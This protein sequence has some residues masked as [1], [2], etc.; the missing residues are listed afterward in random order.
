MSFSLVSSHTHLRMLY[1]AICA[2]QTS[3]VAVN[4]I[5]FAYPHTLHIVSFHH[6]IFVPFFT[7]F[8]LA[9]YLSSIPFPFSSSFTLSFLSFPSSSFTDQHI[10]T[11][12]LRPFHF[13]PFI[14]PLFLISF[15]Y[16]IYFLI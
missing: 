3:D 13:C 16:F 2:V 1:H 15:F 11:L 4:K 7:L 8:S 9:M 12:L 14:F 10:Y 6:F 5:P